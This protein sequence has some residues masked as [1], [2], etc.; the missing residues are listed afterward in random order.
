MNNNVELLQKTLLFKGSSMEELELA[1]GLFQERLIKSNTTIFT[2]KMPAEALYII[3]SGNV[4]ISMMA[5]EGEE[6]P[7]LLLGPGEFFG[8]LA[9]L[10]EESRLVTARSETAVELLMITRKDF[11]ALMDLDPRSSSRMV[12]AIAKLLAMRVK[13]YS[14]QLKDMLLA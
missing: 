1:L 8:E 14:A 6:K 9:L 3:K 12:T 4:R 2:E 11:Q 5:S 13:A 7:L 10:Q